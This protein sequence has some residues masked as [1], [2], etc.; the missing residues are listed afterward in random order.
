MRIR[1]K[2][3]IFGLIALLGLVGGY[4]YISSQYVVPILMYHRID[5]QGDT[6]SLSVSPDNF[7]HQMRFLSERHYNVIF[8]TELAQA[9][10]SG[11]RLPRNTVVITFD[12]GY[13]DNYRYAY[14][15]LKKYD[16]P[17]TIFVIVDALNLKGYLNDGQLEQML[18]EGL[19]EIGS[20]SLSGAYLPGRDSE[21]LQREIS[22][23]K[24]ELELKLNRPAELFCYPIGGF[25]AEIQ[26]LVKQSGYLAACTTNR[27]WQR[28]RA[29]NDLFALKRIKV[30]DSSANL[31]VFWVKLSGYYNFFRRIRT[32]H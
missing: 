31:L 12:D 20:H 7:L 28:T 16:L 5:Q 32:P 27:G 1:K 18:N 15:V 29:N 23:S 2:F 19:V 8:L 25:T 9:K 3:V 22:L 11:V 10:Q 21:E 24:E 30:T 14:P 26:E 6:S 13:A 4:L 17:A